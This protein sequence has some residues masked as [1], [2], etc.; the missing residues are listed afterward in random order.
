MRIQEIRGQH[1]EGVFEVLATYIQHNSHLDHFDVAKRLR[2]FGYVEP[3]HKMPVFRYLNHDVTEEDRAHAT[4]GALFNS[5][6]ADM[7]MDLS[8]GPQG[9]APTFE[10]CHDIALGHQWLYCHEIPHNHPDAELGR[11]LV[12]IYEITAPKDNIL[13]SMKGVKAFAQQAPD[14]PEKKELLNSMDPFE[15]GYPD[16][17]IMI[18]T[19]HGCRIVDAHFYDNSEYHEF[20]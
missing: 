6:R 18:D 7:R 8:R 11:S 12:V 4:E 2:E 19:S 16:D 9:F 14:S 1:L 20:R 5:I 17:E 13:W 15:G 3:E 10:K